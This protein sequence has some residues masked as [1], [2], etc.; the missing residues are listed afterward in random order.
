MGRCRRR[1]TRQSGETPW[2]CPLASSSEGSMTDYSSIR[3]T[4]A[5]H[6]STAALEKSPRKASTSSSSS[7]SSASSLPSATSQQHKYNN[8]VTETKETLCKD[9][10]D[11]PL[12]ANAVKVKR[13]PK[14]VPTSSSSSSSSSDSEA[15]TRPGIRKMDL[16]SEGE[17]EVQQQQ[18]QMTEVITGHSGSRQ[19]AQVRPSP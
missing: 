7:S 14:V 10:G 9:S 11:E 19:V 13:K 17:M 6:I 5:R 16:H 1:Y 18:Q 8:T 15:D 4:E 12:Y 3:S 2:P